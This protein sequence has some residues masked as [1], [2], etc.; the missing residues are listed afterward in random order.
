MEKAQDEGEPS[1][2]AEVEL[3]VTV[4]KNRNGQ[5]NEERALTFNRP[6]LTIKDRANPW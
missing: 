3:K 4:L 6:L 5:V 1:L 2:G